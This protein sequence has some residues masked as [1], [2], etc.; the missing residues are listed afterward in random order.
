M[1]HILVC[2]ERLSHPIELI[3]GPKQ[4]NRV[5]KI[6]FSVLLV[7]F[8]PPCRMKFRANLICLLAGFGCQHTE[9]LCSSYE[10]HSG[11][12]NWVSK[13]RSE[14]YTTTCLQTAVG[15]TTVQLEHFLSNETYPYQQGVGMETRFSDMVG[16]N[17]WI[18]APASKTLGNA[19]FTPQKR[20]FRSAQEVF[21][22]YTFWTLTSLL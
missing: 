14:S 8:G 12:Q 13:L 3:F 2:H 4:P 6:K 9:P 18:V 7:F 11:V 10:L 15:T 5:S 1:L 19:I 22:F 21:L 20:F 17:K 16:L